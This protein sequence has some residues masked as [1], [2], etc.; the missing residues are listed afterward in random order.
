MDLLESGDDFVLKTS[1]DGSAFATA[2]TAAAAT[3]IVTF[4][5]GFLPLRPPREPWPQDDRFLAR[6]A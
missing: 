1:P 6:E 5:I 4:G 2:L 3:G